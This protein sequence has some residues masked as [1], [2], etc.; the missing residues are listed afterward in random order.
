MLDSGG[1]GK[2][3]KKNNSNDSPISTVM[4]SADGEE[5][6][7]VLGISLATSA[8]KVVNEGGM[9]EVGTTVLESFPPLPTQVTTFA[10]NAPGKSSYANVTSKP[11]GK[12][13]NILTLF[14]SRGNEIDVVVPMESIRAISDRFANTTYDFFL[15][16]RVAYPVVASYVRNTWGKYELARFIFSS[17]T[18]THL[19]LDSYTSDMC[20]QSWDSSSYARVMIELRA[21]IELKDNVVMTL[22]KI[23]GE[24]HYICDVRVEYQWGSTNMVNNVATLSGSSLMNVDN[25]IPIIDKIEKFKDLLSSGQAILVDNAG[26]P[27]KKVEF[28]DDYDSKDEVTSVDNDIAYSLASERVAFGT[29][30]LLEQWKDS[31]G[32]GDYE[33]DPYDEDMYEGTLG[34]NMDRLNQCLTRLLGYSPSNLAMDGLDAILENEDVDYVLVWV[35]LHGVLVTTFR[36]YGLSTNAHLMLDSYTADIGIES[37]G[38][39][40]YARAMIELRAD[41]DLKDTIMVLGH[42]QD[43]CPK[44]IGSEV[45][46]NMKNPNQVLRGVLVGLNVRFKPVKQVYRH[47]SKKNNVNTS[48]NKKKYMDS[49]K[50][51][52]KL[53]ID[54]KVSLVNEKGKALKKVD[55]SG[56][57]DSEDKVEP[58][59]NEMA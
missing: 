45:E 1:G 59:D 12:K 27:L 58:V 20:M 38:R 39:S 9:N 11:N 16:K 33:E 25:I 8:H 51:L 30:S 42:V 46:K 35:K 19:M 29:Q 36:E 4:E 41:V 24:G 32:N 31:Y 3:K 10:R 6:N 21:D 22:P 52:E 7:E 56:D 48:G 28:L 43:E 44:N 5:L 53:I 57:H 37:Y 40:S 15:G 18:G 49:R 2:K 54:G 47:V 17:S 55:Y 14:T 34:V 13:L 26:N 50:E 23:K